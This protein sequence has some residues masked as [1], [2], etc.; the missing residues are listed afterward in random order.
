M[1]KNLSEKDLG[2]HIATRQ[3]QRIPGCLFCRIESWKQEC[4]RWRKLMPES[5][6][7]NGYIKRQARTNKNLRKI[8]GHKSACHFPTTL[9]KPTPEA[10]A[11][12]SSGFTTSSPALTRS[13][14]LLC[15][16]PGGTGGISP[17]SQQGREGL[18]CWRRSWNN[19]RCYCCGGQGQ[20]TAPPER[21]HYELLECNGGD[22]WEETQ[23]ALRKAVL[24]ANL[25]HTSEMGIQNFTLIINP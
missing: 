17:K 20:N 22:A 6:G 14:N 4:L 9:C 10:E 24:L 1:L 8:C 23:R 3:H 25:I 11:A 13:C 5:E 12:N 7:P 16:H 21:L 2:P 15:T 18:F 19:N